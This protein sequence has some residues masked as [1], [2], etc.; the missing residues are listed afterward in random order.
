MKVHTE[1]QSRRFS[2]NAI[3]QHPRFEAT[4]DVGGEYP[5]QRGLHP[6]KKKK[7]RD[8]GHRQKK[9]MNYEEPSTE[10]LLE[11]KKLARDR[12]G[13]GI[14]LQNRE[15]NENDADATAQANPQL[16]SHAAHQQPKGTKQ[17]QSS[18]MDTRAIGSRASHTPEGGIKSQTQNM[19][20]KNNEPE[21]SNVTKNP[22]PDGHEDQ[23]LNEED[24]HSHIVHEKGQNEQEFLDDHGIEREEVIMTKHEYDQVQDEYELVRREQQ[25][26]GY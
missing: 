1:G 20:T 5:Q 4:N 6:K 19:N 25:R 17:G 23:L 7:R 9:S 22:T 24:D 13:Y 16:R 8:H 26:C 14:E 18:A 10:L 15:L 3:N 2:D 21:S 12:A 11:E